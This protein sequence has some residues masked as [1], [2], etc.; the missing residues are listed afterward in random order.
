[1]LDYGYR[2]KCCLA[3]IRF[4]FKRVKD[5]K[6]KKTIMICNK[7]GTRDVSIINKEEVEIQS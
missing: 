5:T 3:T 7:C 6:Q 2:S 4:G 1:M